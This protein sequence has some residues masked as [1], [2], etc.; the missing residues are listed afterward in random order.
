MARFVYRRLRGGIES[1]VTGLRG[2]LWLLIVIPAG[3]LFAGGPGPDAARSLSRAWDLGH[4]VAFFAWTALWL[5][6]GAAARMPRR[7]RWAATLA[8]CALVAVLTEGAQW[9]AGRDAS[10]HDASRDMLGG[11]LA[12][13]WLDSA[14]GHLTPVLRRAGRAGSL[15]VL[16]AALAP[17]AAALADEQLGRL[18]FPV[19]ADFETPFEADRWEGSA[20]HAID[21]SR[22]SHGNASLRVELIPADYSGVALVRAPRDWRGYRRLRLE[23]FNAGTETLEV[24]GRIHDGEHDRRGPSYGERY[25][26]AFRLTPGWT[27]LTIDLAAAERGPAARHL[28]MSDIRGF[29]L[30][31]SRLPAPCTI[32]LDNVRL[33]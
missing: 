6:T 4:V 31:V 14:R 3:L 27:A 12:L 10:V 7:K 13:A 15:V 28:D 9:L 19:L 20:A 16:G 5:R 24:F 26:T 23:A 11:L 29:M 17:L 22:A 8:M 1:H 25:N 21:P 33:E 32:F 30:F 18:A 2:V